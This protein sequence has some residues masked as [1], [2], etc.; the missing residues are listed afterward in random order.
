VTYEY[1]EDFK[2]SLVGTFVDNHFADDGNT[3]NRFIPSYEVFDLLAEYRITKNVAI[4]GGI[5]NLFDEQY[6]SR[7]RSNGIDPANPVNAF[8][9]ATFTY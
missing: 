7:I 5:N 8:V 3:A 9:G 2:L 6:Y 4:N 1:G